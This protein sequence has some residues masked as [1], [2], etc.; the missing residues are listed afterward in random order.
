[1]TEGREAA[2]STRQRWQ[3]NRRAFD[4]L[5]AA[6]DVD[7]EAASGKYEALRGK[8]INLFAWER[9]ETPDEL[10]D[11][12]LDRL[13]RKLAEGIAL[14]NPDQYAFG[15]ARRMLLEQHR[16]NYIKRTALRALRYFGGPGTRDAELLRSAERCLA[17]LPEESRDLIERYYAEDRD[18]IASELDISLNALRNRVLRIREKILGCI[19]KGA[20]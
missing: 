19:T 9:C 10:A 3:L 6:L 2:P 20:R 12:A 18:V 15:I 7:R 14:Q 16:A 13:A 5:L 4:L 11:E 17:E 8:L 1:M